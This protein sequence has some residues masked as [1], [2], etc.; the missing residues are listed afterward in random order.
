MRVVRGRCKNFALSKK[1]SV[2]KQTRMFR[3]TEDPVIEARDSAAK[4]EEEK[5]KDSERDDLKNTPTFEIVY[6]L[7]C[8]AAMTGMLN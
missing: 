2:P 7:E 3:T 5:P 4:E 8:F 1:V 6:S